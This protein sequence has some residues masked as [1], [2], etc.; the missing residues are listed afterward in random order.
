MWFAASLKRK[1]GNNGKFLPPFLGK[2]WD[3]GSVVRPRIP[4]Y[5]RGVKVLIKGLR[6]GLQ[7]FDPHKGIF[8]WLCKLFQKGLQATE[9]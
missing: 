3:L 6:W 9:L 5:R 2:F 4:P 1:F 8:G 7:P